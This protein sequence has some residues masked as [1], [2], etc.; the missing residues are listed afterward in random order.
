MNL[1]CPS[2]GQVFSLA[3]SVA[4]NQKH[5]KTVAL[6]QKHPNGCKGRVDVD[7]LMI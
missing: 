7:S 4:L 3:E 6:D 5:P 2:H 1:I